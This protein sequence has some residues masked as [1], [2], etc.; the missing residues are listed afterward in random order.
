[1]VSRHNI[2]DTRDALAYMVSCTLASVERLATLKKP[3]PG[4]FKR[5][6]S[7]AQFGCEHLQYAKYDM[8]SDSRLKAVVYAGSVEKYAAAI[9]AEMGLTK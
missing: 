5:Q 7:I 6:I 9:R 4:E 8:H 3:P 1:M 2:R